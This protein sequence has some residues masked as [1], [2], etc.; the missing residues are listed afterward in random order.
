[1]FSSSFSSGSYP[2][3]LHPP[4]RELFCLILNSG[5]A[6]EEEENKERQTGSR[7]LFWILLSWREPVQRLIVVSWFLC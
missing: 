6:V 7:S 5:A 2:I 3:F 4:H 1:M